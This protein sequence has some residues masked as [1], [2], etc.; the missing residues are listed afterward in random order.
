M[1]QSGDTE[2][3]VPRPFQGLSSYCGRELLAA[4]KERRGEPQGRLSRSSCYSQPSFGPRAG[5]EMS[6]HA[7]AG[8]SG[9]G[10]AR[11]GRAGGKPGLELGRSQE[12]EKAESGVFQALNLG[13]AQRERS[14]PP[15]LGLLGRKS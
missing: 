14:S 5:A 2:R 3:A 6:P 15:T 12:Q 10:A 1:L 7:H 9:K 11:T 8:G 4:L 13:A